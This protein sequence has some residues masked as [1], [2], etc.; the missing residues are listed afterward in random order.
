MDRID[1]E[2]ANAWYYAKDGELVLYKDHVA[3]LTADRAR[4][5]DE[6][7]R[8]RDD[9]GLERIDSYGIREDYDRLL[10]FVNG[11]TTDNEVTNKESK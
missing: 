7:R 9:P 6:I 11:G 2:A 5:S 10:A 8:L 4:I 1:I 3:V